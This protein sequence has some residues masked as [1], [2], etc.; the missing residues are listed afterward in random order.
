MRKN[1]NSLSAAALPQNFFSLKSHTVHQTGIIL[2]VVQVTV[3][4]H[5]F[6]YQKHFCLAKHYTIYS[7]IYVLHLKRVATPPSQMMD[8]FVCAHD[9]WCRVMRL[10]IVYSSSLQALLFFPFKKRILF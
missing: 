3:A 8:A 7:H 9:L 2:L 5:L 6:A 10:F 4:N 1:K